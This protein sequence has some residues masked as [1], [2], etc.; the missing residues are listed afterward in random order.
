M[1]VGHER[2]FVASQRAYRATNTSKDRTLCLVQHAVTIWI[3]E[4]SNNRN[5]F[6]SF[7]FKTSK[8]PCVCVCVCLLWQTLNVLG[9]FIR[10]WIDRFACR[11]ES[12]R[13]LLLVACC[14]IPIQY[15]Q[16]PSSPILSIPSGIII[17]NNH[18]S[19]VR[20]RCWWLI[21]HASAKSEIDWWPT[22]GSFVVGIG[23]SLLKSHFQFF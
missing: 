16:F 13:C 14:T 1:I 18:D 3:Y 8:E 4:W 6:V 11:T 10:Q 7:S 12:V 15:L 17:I 5:V 2:K 21:Q 23:V 22:L 9:Q 19:F 20:I